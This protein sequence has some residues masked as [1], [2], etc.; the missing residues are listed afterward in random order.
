MSGTVNNL[1]SGPVILVHGGAGP[2]GSEARRQELAV[3][4][5]ALALRCHAALRDGGAAVEIAVAAVRS[6]EDDP[7]FN[8]GL[9][10]KLQVDGQARLSASL[11][12]GARHRFSGV[13]NAIGPANPVDLALHLQE[14]ASR[15]LAGEGAL[16]RARALGLPERDA[17]TPERLAAWRASREGRHGTVGAVVLD[18][19]G[20]L[21]AATST[22]GRGG[23]EVG[24][25]SD[26]CTV[27]GTF[28][29]EAAACSAT[30]VGEEINEVGLCVRLVQGV[31]LGGDVL[32]SARRLQARMAAQACDAGFIAV[33]ARG[34][35]AAGRTSAWM[36]WAGVDGSGQ[37]VGC[38]SST[39]RPLVEGRAP[40]PEGAP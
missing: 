24:R 6:L 29:S 18:A 28:A 21:A 22:G 5:E 35:W 13:V 25:V 37:L 16:A 7:R 10:A 3:F 23:E 15:V 38:R 1:A 2:A 33:D 20:R 14:D 9:G 32:E 39:A 19:S 12:D 40:E 11:M 17:R 27:S 34:G 8:A 36:H 31:E 26:S 4:L 30:G